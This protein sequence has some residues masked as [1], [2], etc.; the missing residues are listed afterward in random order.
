MTNAVP[1]L[2]MNWL[3]CRAVIPFRLMIHDTLWQPEVQLFSKANLSFASGIADI[4]SAVDQTRIAAIAALAVGIA[5][6]ALVA[7]RGRRS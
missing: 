4:Q 6:L 2:G 7:I 1:I 5:A 3:H